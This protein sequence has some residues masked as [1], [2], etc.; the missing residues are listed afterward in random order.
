[1]RVP[2]LGAPRVGGSNGR[3]PGAGSTPGGPVWGE[4]RFEAGVRIRLK[5][6]GA[7]TGRGSGCQWDPVLG[8]MAGILTKQKS[9]QARCAGIKVL[10][11]SG[12]VLIARGLRCRRHRT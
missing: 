4:N 5:S 9:L 2:P 6:L 8:C 1:M 12:G 7:P 3:G 11:V 10:G